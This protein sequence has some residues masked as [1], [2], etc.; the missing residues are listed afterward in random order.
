MDML[1]VLRTKR[2]GGRL[3]DAQ[4]RWFIEGFTQGAIADEPRSAPTE[5]DDDEPAV[6]L[7]QRAFPLIQLMRDAAANESSIRWREA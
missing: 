6:G 1:E 4:I 2:D 3:S 5:D 7:R